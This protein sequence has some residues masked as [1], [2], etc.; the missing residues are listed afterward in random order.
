MI[1]FKIGVVTQFYHSF[2]CFDRGQQPLTTWDDPQSRL[3][4]TTLRY[5]TRRI[6]R[7]W[8]VSVTKRP[9]LIYKIEILPCCGCM[10]LACYW[11]FKEGKL[12]PPTSQQ[13]VLSV[14]VK[15]N[16]GCPSQAQWQN[17]FSWKGMMISKVN[18]GGPILQTLISWEIPAGLWGQP[19]NRSTIFVGLVP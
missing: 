15:Y 5:A 9:W 11:R 1:L 12:K 14:V 6:T 7:V 3:R 8:H 10:V 19:A 17:L 2:F 18:F 16:L 13:P 4:S